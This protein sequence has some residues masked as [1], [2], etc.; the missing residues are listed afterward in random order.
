MSLWETILE[1]GVL[2]ATY[3]FPPMNYIGADGTRQMV[4]LIRSWESPGIRAIV[5]KGGRSGKIHN[6]LLRRGTRDDRSRVGR[7][8]REPGGIADSRLQ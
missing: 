7:K 2:T 3:S 8:L 5:I 4:D 6:P 1:N